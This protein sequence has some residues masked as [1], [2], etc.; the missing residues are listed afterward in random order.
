M[1][2][3]TPPSLRPGEHVI[4]VD[5]VYHAYEVAGSGPVCLVHPGGPGINSGYLRM[6]PLERSLTM[7]Y[8]DP[9]GTGRS[10]MSPGGDYSVPTYARFSEGVIKH[11]GVNR[12]FF[13]GH[14]HGGCVGLELAIRNPG[15]LGG[16]VAYSTGPVYNSMLF[17]EATRQMTAFAERWPDR[18]EAAEAARVW[19]AHM[20]SR[21]EKVTDRRS[22]DAFL[23]GILP[24]HFADFRK[25]IAE[26]SSFTL[27]VTFDPARENGRWDAR[28]RIER[29]DV[30]TL[31]A[32]GRHDFFYPRKWS[33]ELV[34]KIP[35]AQMLALENSGHFAHMESERATFFEAV[36]A[37]V[38]SRPKGE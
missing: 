8:L 24:A 26:R 15:L 30:P 31:V 13:L 20:V 12:P 21:T 4:E 19:N 5:G 11:L 32:S 29:I 7:I 6:P 38:T 17:E 10:D 33:E 37:F 34:A 36:A 28:R 2:C 16:L 22:H 14:S 27:S 18:P 9:A 35:N 3:G 23:L 25:T 1:H